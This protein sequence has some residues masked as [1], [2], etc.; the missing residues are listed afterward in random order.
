MDGG[1]LS[2]GCIRVRVQE[3]SS[4]AVDLNC[5]DQTHWKEIPG[6]NTGS[7]WLIPRPKRSE[8][9]TK[10]FLLLLFGIGERSLTRLFGLESNRK[11]CGN[12]VQRDEPPNHGSSQNQVLKPFPIFFLKGEV[13][14]IPMSQR[15]SFNL[16]T[17]NQHPLLREE[18]ELS[19]KPPSGP[20]KE[21]ITLHQRESS[22]FRKR[23]HHLANIAK[24]LILKLP[25][26]RP[27]DH[28]EI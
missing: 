17:L 21:R 22:S 14:L 24:L 13:R 15:S 1:D 7:K 8:E 26:P 28:E 10:L 4:V 27:L 11:R 6:G 9:G 5:L 12:V 16:T 25:I 23:H 18:V 20:C 19:I 2:L 3:L